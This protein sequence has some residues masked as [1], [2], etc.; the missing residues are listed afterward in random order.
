[1]NKEDCLNTKQSVEDVKKSKIVVKGT[2]YRIERT[3]V[4]HAD[5]G[6]RFHAIVHDTD[7]NLTIFNPEIF[8]F[9]DGSKLTE[10]DLQQPYLYYPSL[11]MDW[12]II[13]LMLV[14]FLSPKAST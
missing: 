10:K 7:G 11:L 3:E 2:K 6:E 5:F 13:P 12:P 8:E 4:D 14:S 1:V 9:S